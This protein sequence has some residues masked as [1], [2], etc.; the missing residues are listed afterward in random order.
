MKNTNGARVASAADAPLT[1][2]I[3]GLVARE[4]RAYLL[5]SVEVDNARSEGV[6]VRTLLTNAIERLRKIDPQQYEVRVTL[7]EQEIGRREAQRRERL[8]AVED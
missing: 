8:A 2:Q 7:G 4:T 5:G 6:I 3:S 1:E